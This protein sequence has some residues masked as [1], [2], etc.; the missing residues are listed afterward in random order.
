MELKKVQ[1]RIIKNKIE[2]GF[3][4][5][6]INQEFLLLYGEVNEAYMAHLKGDKENLK[7]ELAD[8][9]IYL[10]GISEMFGVD[11]ET[12]IEKKIKKNESRT[13]VTLENG[14]HVKLNKL[15][16]VNGNK[17]ATVVGKIVVDNECRVDLFDVMNKISNVCPNSASD[18]L[19]KLKVTDFCGRE[20][21][22]ECLENLVNMNESL[23]NISAGKSYFIDAGVLKD[24]LFRNY[25][26]ANLK[27]GT[28]LFLYTYGDDYCLT[29]LD[30]K[31]I[32]EQLKF[33]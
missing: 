15:C 4:V 20:D 26:V 7:E 10:L 6:D 3:G 1:E 19:A 22:F 5:G 13:Y 31:E 33:Q 32:A 14:T 17:I 2:K 23:A 18:A 25:A 8:V 16:D 24:D 12:E 9:A 28:E 29:Y 11:L 30:Q 21:E 27:P